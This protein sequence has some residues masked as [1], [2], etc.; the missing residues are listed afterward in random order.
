MQ[1]IATREYLRVVDL[2]GLGCVRL[3]RLL[4]LGGGEGYD[5]LERYMKD[6]ADEAIRR[7]HQELTGNRTV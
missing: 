6:C 3:N 4:R 2:Y 5:Q 7:V 1:G